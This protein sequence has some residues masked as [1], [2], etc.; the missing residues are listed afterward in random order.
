MS[1]DLGDVLDFCM[2]LVF[3]YMPVLVVLF[4]RDR[5]FLCLE[6]TVVLLEICLDKIDTTDRLQQINKTIF[7]WMMDDG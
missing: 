5:V 7:S 4:N 2:H 6:A 1:V 3:D